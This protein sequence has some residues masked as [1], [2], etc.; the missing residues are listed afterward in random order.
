MKD[1]NTCSLVFYLF[2]LAFV[3][4]IIGCEPFEAITD[5]Y[6]DI[7]DTVAP[8][9]ND[10]DQE[11]GRVIGTATFTGPNTV[12]VSYTVLNKNGEFIK[13]NTPVVCSIFSVDDNATEFQLTEKTTSGQVSGCGI[14]NAGVAE[15]FIATAV[16]EGISSEPISFTLGPEG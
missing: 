2:F 12:S 13:D 5:T 16:T 3:I 8:D 10:G 7:V 4:G 6:A 14:T 15:S 9:D 1:K 11:V